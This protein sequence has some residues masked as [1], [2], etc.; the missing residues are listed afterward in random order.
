M[1]LIIPCAG[2][3]TRR[4]PDTALTPKILLDY[5]GQPIIEHI[6]EP[7]YRSGQ[8]DKIV[9]VLGP[10]HG[11][12]IIDYLKRQWVSYPEGNRPDIK[13]VWQNEPLG[14]GH[15]VMQAR[16]EVLSWRK[17][18]QPVMVHTDDAII[19]RRVEDVDDPSWRGM[20]VRCMVNCR[21]SQI[22]VAWRDDVSNYGVVTND[23]NRAYTAFDR[24]MRF[25]E[26][27]N[28]DHGGLAITGMYFIRNARLMFRCLHNQ[29]RRKQTHRGEYQFT[30]V[31]QEMIDHGEKF[32][33]YDQH[34]IDVGN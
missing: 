33:T 12:Q 34:W 19:S 28:W 13:F 16:P 25:V 22:G 24:N 31:L 29:Y 27:P 20:M 4:L 5:K 14:F 11:A 21:H 9:F 7:I 10:K 8:F 3:G 26:K 23:T 17:W 30:T 32:Q 2:K 18:N 1:V 15:A 6:L